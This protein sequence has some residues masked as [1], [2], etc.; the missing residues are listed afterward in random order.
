MS[1]PRRLAFIDLMFSWPPHGGADVDLYQTLLGLQNLGHDVHLFYAGYEASWERGCADPRALPFPAT[2]IDFSWRNLN[3]RAA[4]ARFREAIDAWR[5]DAVSVHHGFFL[6]PFIA[7]AMAHYPTVGRYYAYELVCPR[8]GVLFRDGATCPNNY[9][10]TPDVCRRCALRQL[11]A[12]LTQWRMVAWT[13]EYLVARAFLPAYHRKVVESVRRF[14]AVIVSNELMKSQLAGFNDNTVILPGGVRVEQFTYEPPEPHD[15]KR[16]LLAGRVEE[17]LKGLEVLREAGAILARTR[18]D[19]EIHATYSNV[20]RDTPWFKAIGWHDHDAVIRLNQQADICVVPSIW[21]EPFGLAAV[22]AM[23][24][25]RPVC[26][27]RV[28]GLQDIVRDGQTG[29][30]FD[31]GDS[32]ALARCLADLLDDAD[33]RLRMG[34]AGRGVVEREYDWDRVI[35]RHW[36]P[37]LERLLP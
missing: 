8:D 23:A 20:R 16:I 6:K 7:D 5:P 30:L 11:K 10:R 24:A 37:L 21:D 27:S 29:F 36:P 13:Q 15:T 1:T 14:N 18:S 3:P 17:P 34:E 19:F 25:G 9:L 22:E 4:P 35:E 33:L 31:R 28:G 2:R 32:A 12:R 26:A